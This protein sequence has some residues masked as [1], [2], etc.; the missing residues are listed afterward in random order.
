MSKLEDFFDKVKS[1]ITHYGITFEDTITKFSRVKDI[2]T[3]YLDASSGIVFIEVNIKTFEGKIQFN[4]MF[5]CIK[6]KSAPVQFEENNLLLHTFRECYLKD[7]E[8]FNAYVTQHDNDWTFERTYGSL[9]DLMDISLVFN[10]SE[11]T[12]ASST[13]QNFV[14]RYHTNQS[15]SKLLMLDTVSY[16]SFENKYDFYYEHGKLVYGG[17]YQELCLTVNDAY[18][19]NDIYC[20]GANFKDLAQL[21]LMK[22]Y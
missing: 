14:I 21:T 1:I 22:I 12:T 11:N 20:S 17:D 6:T 8:I 13:E 16:L 7:K 2:D 15:C 9:L 5:Q 10:I 4:K 3:Y 18:H 19:L